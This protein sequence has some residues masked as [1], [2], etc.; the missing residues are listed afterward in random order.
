MV[1]VSQQVSSSSLL[2]I[3]NQWLWG[4]EKSKSRG[5]TSCQFHQ[6][7]VSITVGEDDFVTTFLIKNKFIDWDRIGPSLSGHE[8]I[9]IILWLWL[10]LVSLSDFLPF[11][12]FPK[13]VSSL[14]QTDICVFQT[15]LG[16]CSSWSRLLPFILHF[17][18]WVLDLIIN[19]FMNNCHCI[20]YC[21]AQLSLYI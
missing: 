20:V 8:L 6:P 19:T 12:F 4:S 1:W 16:I 7:S 17:I 10:I 2:L 5:K 21:K 18:P 9:P 13:I 15:Y 3:S 11:N 14:Y